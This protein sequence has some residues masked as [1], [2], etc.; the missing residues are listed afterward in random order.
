MDKQ[1]DDVMCPEE[2]FFFFGGGGGAN[3]CPR[4]MHSQVRTESEGFKLYKNYARIRY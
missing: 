2:F 1:R 4:Y 3:W